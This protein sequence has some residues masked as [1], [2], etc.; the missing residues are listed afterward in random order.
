MVLL[1][2]SLSSECGEKTEGGVEK[3]SEDAVA[4]EHELRVALMTLPVRQALISQA[5]F[6]PAER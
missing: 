4:A 2:F 6:S 3:E 5:I 1:K